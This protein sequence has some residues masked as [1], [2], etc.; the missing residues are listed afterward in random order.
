MKRDNMMKEK[1]GRANFIRN[2]GRL[3]GAAM[4]E[5]GAFLPGMQMMQWAASKGIDINNMDDRSM[6][7]AQRQLG[8]GRDE[9]DQAIKMA[10][11]MP[12]IM[13]E[14]KSKKGLD[15]YTQARGQAAKSVGVEGIKQRF[16]QA[17]QKVNN[18]LQKVGQDFFNDGAE[19]IDNFLTKL[20]GEYEEKFSATAV[21][22][23]QQSTRGGGGDGLAKA[24]GA[25]ALKGG[26][27]ALFGGASAGGAAAFNS[28]SGGIFGLLKGTSDK[29]RFAAAGY[30]VNEK[31]NEGLRARLGEIADISRAANAPPDDKFIALGASSPGWLKDAYASGAISGQGEDRIKSMGVQIEKSGSPEQKAAW[32]SA[33]TQQEKARIVSG[34]A[35]GAFGSTTEGMNFAMPEVRSAM[36]GK[37]MTEA[38]K[39]DVVGNAFF[40]AKDTLANEGERGEFGDLAESK[41]TVS[42]DLRKAT[43]TFLMSDEAM[44]VAQKFM[45]GGEGADKLVEQMKGI[46]TQIDQGDKTDEG[47][48]AGMRGIKTAADYQQGIIS[49]MSPE[50]AEKSAAAKNN[51]SVEEVRS[52]TSTVKQVLTQKEA[53]G[54]TSIA[55][56]E[57]KKATEDI[58][59][60][61]KAGLATYDSVSGKISLTTAGRRGLGDSNSEVVA[62]QLLQATS[63][64]AEAGRLAGDK[65]QAGRMED[66]IRQASDIENAVGASTA[67]KSVEEQKRIAKDLVAQGLPGGEELMMQASSQGRLEKGIARKGGRQGIADFLGAGLDKEHRS[68]LQAAS[69]PEAAAH[70]IADS[71]G[72]KDE[73]KIL[74]SIKAVG[75][76]GAGIGAANRTLRDLEG[77]DEFKAVKKAQSLEQA[78]ERDPLQAEANKHL[79][80]IRNQSK[81]QIEVLKAIGNSTKEGAI[82]MAKLKLSDAEDKGANGGSP[83]PT[84]GNK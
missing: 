41:N 53:E 14:M 68:M 59:R 23:Y 8:M 25:G 61:S 4:Q 84:P 40:A 5:F 19:M 11:N 18:Q 69:S 10:Q 26:G 70:I 37:G 51:I 82:A 77:S 9:A 22:A 36:F 56:A 83:A 75:K 38:Q 2:E 55:R 30:Q 74:A 52:Q 1:V 80:A 54:Y 35:A 73:S 71:L 42:D 78:A 64:K 50:E 57:G 45:A 46:Q 43:A 60:L 12:R 29:D 34:M 15:E 63:L 33:K 28:G 21:Q 39:R 48:L 27:G 76:G 79:E 31:T 20:T 65:S 66:L 13:E 7:F 16:E 72:V 47:R 32:A 49:G 3:R 44:G 24:I 58:N 67:D 81:D 6:L 62:K 17:K